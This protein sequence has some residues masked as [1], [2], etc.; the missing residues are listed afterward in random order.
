M[1]IRGTFSTVR[2]DEQGR[3]EDGKFAS[4]SGGGQKSFRE[5]ANTASYNA[6]KATNPQDR[7]R[8]HELA[9]KFHK[10]AGKRG[11]PESQ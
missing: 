6:R 10:E 5:R 1:S 9:L 7:A 4:G 2:G 3:D 11:E 8:F